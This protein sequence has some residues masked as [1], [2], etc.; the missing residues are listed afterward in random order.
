MDGPQRQNGADTFGSPSLS[1][2]ACALP[3]HRLARSFRPPASNGQ[4]LSPQLAVA[5][6]RLASLE[7]H[8]VAEVLLLDVLVFDLVDL[9]AQPILDA[10]DCV[11][12]CIESCVPPLGTSECAGP[13][14]RINEAMTRRPRRRA[15]ISDQLLGS[16][17]QLAARERRR[18]SQLSSMKSQSPVMAA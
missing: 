9:F 8:E 12:S 16:H 3:N 1:A 18:Q 13:A 6:A 5:H 10:V 4:S 15:L 2:A 14:R 7:V 11:V 17:P